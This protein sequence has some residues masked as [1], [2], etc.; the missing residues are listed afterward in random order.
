MQGPV[1][2]SATEILKTP[3]LRLGKISENIVLPRSVEVKKVVAVILG[4]LAAFPI[5]AFG[6]IV[7]GHSLLFFILVELFVSILF[8]LAVSYSPIKGESFSTWLGLASSSKV[9][10]K[11]MHRGKEVRAYIG[12]APLKYSAQGSVRIVPGAVSVPAGAYDERG[13]PL[14]ATQVLRDALMQQNAAPS[15]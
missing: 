6:G 10:G 12:I 15:N 13:V 2:L 3:P 5:F 1:M 9:S 14:K 7:I 11:V 4:L 8:L